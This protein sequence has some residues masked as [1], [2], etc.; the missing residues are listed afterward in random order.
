MTTTQ[1][2]YLVM[3]A[4]YVVLATVSTHSGN[5]FIGQ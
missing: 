2:V 3:G 4:L 5:H 1:I